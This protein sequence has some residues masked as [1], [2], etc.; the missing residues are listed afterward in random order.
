LTVRQKDRAWLGRVSI[1]YTGLTDRMSRIWQ[2][3]TQSFKK[4]LAFE[5]DPDP[6]FKSGLISTSD[7]KTV[8]KIG[9]YGADITTLMIPDYQPLSSGGR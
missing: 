1:S 4:Y 2:Y 5:T 6:S 9:I 7:P 8:C 3:A